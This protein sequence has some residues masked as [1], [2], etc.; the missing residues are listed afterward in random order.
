MTD[1]I[2]TFTNRASQL[3]TIVFTIKSDINIRFTVHRTNHWTVWAHCGNSGP[4]EEAFDL[5]AEK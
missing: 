4:D 1:S 5:R 3:L 2:L